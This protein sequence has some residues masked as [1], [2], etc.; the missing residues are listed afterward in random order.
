MSCQ[1]SLPPRGFSLHIPRCRDPP[2]VCF[3]GPMVIQV[4]S[5]GW[6]APEGLSTKSGFSRAAHLPLLSHVCVRTAPALLCLHNQPGGNRA[7]FR[8]YNL[9]APSLQKQSGGFCAL[10]SK[11]L[12]LSLPTVQLRGRGAGGVFGCAKQF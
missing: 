6:A 12:P 5:P 7:A 1:L 10:W 3:R 9:I 11:A 2:A 4:W 8:L